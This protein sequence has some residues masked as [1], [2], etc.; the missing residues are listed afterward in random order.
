MLILVVL[1]LLFLYFSS[2]QS[3][4]LYFSLL[5][6]MFFVATMVFRVRYK[7]VLFLSGIILV[8][9]SVSKLFE[10]QVAASM[11]NSISFSLFTISVI[12]LIGKKIMKSYFPTFSA[13]YF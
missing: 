11:L 9:A 8:A 6:L 13:I 3:Q 10:L 7:F 4:D 1:S 5:S 12:K 2:I